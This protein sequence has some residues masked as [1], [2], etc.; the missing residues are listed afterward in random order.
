VFSTRRRSMVKQEGRL[1]RCTTTLAVTLAVGFGVW[2]ATASSGVAARGGT[3]VISQP[4]DF[5]TLDFQRQT[6]SS[7]AMITSF[8]YDSLITYCK[9]VSTRRL[10]AVKFCPYLAD[11]WTKTPNSV[12]FHIRKG[13]RC[14][15]GTPINAKVVAD[16][17]NRMLDV[18]VS[19]A[20]HFGGTQGNVAAGIAPTGVGPFTVTRNDR[21]NT[22]TFRSAKKNAYLLNG[23]NTWVL[24]ANGVAKIMCPA[25]LRN[26]DAIATGGDWGSGAYRLVSAVHNSQ[27]VLQLNRAWTWGPNGT[28]ALRTGMP[29]R[30][31]I[32]II[33][34]QTTAVNEA[35]AGNID[36]ISP[37]PDQR[38]RVEA[39][40]KFNRVV[41]KV[42]V[43]TQGFQ[44]GTNANNIYINTVRV[45]DR[46]LR[47]A[48]L[49]VINPSDLAKA[50]GIE[51]YDLYKSLIPPGASC[52][53]KAAQ[54]DYPNG[55]IVQARALLTRNGYTYTGGQIRRGG[56]QPTVNVIVSAS[57]NPGWGDYLYAQWTT[58]GI[59]VKLEVPNPTIYA[60]RSLANDYDAVGSGSIPNVG[61]ASGAG[62]ARGG[63]N[64]M[65]STPAYDQYIAAGLSTLPPAGCKF[66]VKASQI[67]NQQGYYKMLFRRWVFEYVRKGLTIETWGQLPAASSFSLVSAR[68]QKPFRSS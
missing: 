43:N 8:M 55:S 23:F 26:P 25:G 14:H 51:G 9:D 48:L 33:A 65:V 30:I 44:W 67:A 63:S 38:A 62:A 32:R 57:E 24:G 20:T 59:N 34:D 21:R 46:I 64:L 54:L 50:A 45:P 4:S 39:S 58:L 28:S 40:G 41:R 47:R 52:F 12:T 29:D 36:V 2:T 35:L 27:V 31:V 18:S 6:A 13:P 10:G 42:A 66:W 16:S 3:L 15:D 19:L 5:T 1:L 60:A 37:P 53:T 56:Q 61:F 11:S 17:L 49:M 68:I 7:N 22:V